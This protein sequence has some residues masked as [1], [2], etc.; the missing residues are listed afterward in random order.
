MSK[1]I[2]VTTDDLMSVQDAAKALSRPRY[3]IYRW[4]DAGKI[5]GLRL[6]GILFIPVSEVER[7]KGEA[8]DAQVR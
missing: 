3:T 8:S 7:I 1:E 5:I 2:K 4:I 6:G